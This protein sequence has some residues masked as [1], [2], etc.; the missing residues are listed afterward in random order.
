MA[1]TSRSAAPPRYHVLFA[2]AGF[3]LSIVWIFL[4]FN[5]LCLNVLFDPLLFIF[6]LHDELNPLRKCPSNRKKRNGLTSSDVSLLLRP[7]RE[8]V[9]LKG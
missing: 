4:H 7:M 9:D 6:C 5:L 3:V 8:G 1:A 2:F